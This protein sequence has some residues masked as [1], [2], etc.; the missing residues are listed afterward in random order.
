MFTNDNKAICLVINFSSE[1]RVSLVTHHMSE[2]RQTLRSIA[3]CRI[4]EEGV[5]ARIGTLFGI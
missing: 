4:V 3:K 2:G 1:E 5:D